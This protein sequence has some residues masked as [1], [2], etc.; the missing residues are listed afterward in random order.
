M[1][2]RESSLVLIGLNWLTIGNKGGLEDGNE[3]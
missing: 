3:S 2:L 1:D